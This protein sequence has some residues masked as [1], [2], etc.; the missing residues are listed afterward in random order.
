M[1]LAATCIN[2]VMWGMYVGLLAQ[3]TA[4][5]KGGREV[6]E[7]EL[8]V[9]PQRQKPH[10]PGTRPA[11]LPVTA[12]P[13]GLPGAPQCPGC[14]VANV[15][16]P[17]LAALAADVVDYSTLAFL[18]RQALLRRAQE[19]KE[20]EEEAAKDKE[21][22]R[23]VEKE[24]PEGWQ[25]VHGSDGSCYYWH[26]RSRRRRKKKKEEDAE[27]ELAAKKRTVWTRPRRSLLRQSSYSSFWLISFSVTSISDGVVDLR[28]EVGYVRVVFGALYVV[29]L[30]A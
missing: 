20:E 30:W 21:E 18:T 12:A 6:E 10:P 8:H 1:E 19:E 14:G 13:Q 29:G 28:G 2:A 7:C 15:A 17:L 27:D 4:S 3:E 26:R 11:P 24:D 22:A 5:S 16:T 9:A 23:P 25:A